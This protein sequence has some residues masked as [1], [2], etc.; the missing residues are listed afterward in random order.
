MTGFVLVPDGVDTRHPDNTKV[1]G[2]E[3]FAVTQAVDEV[4]LF[5]IPITVVTEDGATVAFVEPEERP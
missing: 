4:S 3:K 1:R 5:G 2:T